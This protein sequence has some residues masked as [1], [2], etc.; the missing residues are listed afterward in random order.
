VS[1]ER[2]KAVLQMFEAALEVDLLERESW[3]RQSC[4]NDSEL[5]AEVSA[6]LALHAETD[7]FLDPGSQATPPHFS[8]TII[9]GLDIQPGTLLG[10]FIIEQQI[11][12]GGMGLVYRARQI[13]L[14]RP[15]ALK[16]LPPHL[17][18]SESAQTR[19]QRE[20]EAAARLGHP[21]IV[22]VYTTG[23]H[24]GVVYY[25]MELIDGPS[26]SELIDQLKCQPLLELRFCAT[27]PT[28]ANQSQASTHTIAGDKTP[29]PNDIL[30]KPLGLELLNKHGGYFA[31][32]ATLIAQVA[33]GLQYA[34]E[35]K[36]VH[37]DIKPSN[38]LLSSDGEINIGDFGLARIAHEPSFTRTGEVIGTPYYMAPE[39]IY[40]K[41]GTVDARTDI[42]A[43]GATLYELLTLRPPFCGDQ[44]EQVISQIAHEEPLR[45][46]ALNR[47]VPRD[48]ETIALKCLEKPQASRYQTAGELAED[49]RR[50]LESRP[51]SARAITPL[52]RGMRWMQRQRTWTAMLAG[53]CLLA[54][55]AIFFAY[56]THLSESR[57][58]DARFAQLY[59]TAQLAALAGDLKGADKAIDEAEQ[60]GASPA[61]L[62]LLRG[63]LN[64]QAGEFQD[65]CDKLSE[66]V[67][68]RPNSLAAHALLAKA[69]ESNEEHEKC[70]EIVKLLP[71]LNPVTLQ[72][73][74]LLGQAQLPSNF[75]QALATLDEAVQ[76]DKTSV[77][78]RL[79]RGS[80]LTERA[81]DTGDAEQAERALD[82]LRIA[83][84]L[85]E[86]NQYLLGNMLQARL[87][88]ATAYE[89]Q[90]DDKG[91][92]EHLKEAA[93]VAKALEKFPEQYQ[94]H[95]ARGLY[96]EYI[97]DDKQALDAWLAMEE[98]QIAYLVLNLLRQDQVDAA[99]AV[100]DRRLARITRAR[101]TE[102]FRSLL[103]STQAETSNEVV[104][105]FAPQG[106]E[107]LDAVNLHRFNYAN[108]CL[109]GNLEK[110]QQLSREF[111]LSS[112]S[113]SLRDPWRPH[114]VA[115]TSG[116]IDDAEFL[117]RSADSRIALCQAHYFIA[118]TH[119]A[120]GE[121]DLA[122]KHFQAAADQKIVGYLEDAMSRT[123]LVQ[124]ERDP[125]WPKWIVAK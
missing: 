92:Q 45:L 116:E 90:D 59:E 36:V 33:D 72:D 10:D 52:A 9:A 6:L 41:M 101:S 120:S 125:T 99:I 57:W 88:A 46:K 1:I 115:Y 40:P 100:C 60:L 5:A 7:G 109:A 89:L 37:R 17:R 44:R 27:T 76:L 38:L 28:H 66:V 64:L 26:L 79:T 50:Y 93:S 94:S 83:S 58:S 97:G 29:I 111:R 8:A 77:Q 12:A 113:G 49:L 32:V 104:A 43:L 85:L 25:A 105:A 14:N 47:N 78:A 3:V 117:K 15:V 34:H 56:R 16:I 69:Y 70:A 107:T 63:H 124:L 30:P 11:G 54:V 22:A 114:L 75:A 53:M 121:R 118:M 4:S 81:L 123:F 62:L 119:L 23:Q 80:V 95:R 42:Y 24:D 51:I 35:M 84:E 48:L 73:Y 71:T 91:R 74:L 106:E 122:R 39:Q 19:F 82:D 110:A 18:Y 31:T 65:A 67:K 13:S 68:Q 87:V 98:W 102:F 55:A 20:V 103:L 21:N 86:P 2:Q 108:Q 96:F 112:A 61:Q